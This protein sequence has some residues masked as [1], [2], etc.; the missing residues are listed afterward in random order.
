MSTAASQE[1]GY[2]QQ[3]EG[4]ETTSFNT[5]AAQEF[6]A[7]LRTKLDAVLKEELQKLVAGEDITEA[8]YDASM[9]TIDDYLSDMLGQLPVWEVARRNDSLDDMDAAYNGA[10]E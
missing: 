8:Q 5:E 2:L 4:R 3:P 7:N 9:A 6:M 1:Q 10:Q